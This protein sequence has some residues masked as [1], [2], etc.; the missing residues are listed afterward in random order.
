MATF[1]GGVSVASWRAVPKAGGAI[2]MGRGAIPKGAI[3]K[4]GEVPRRRASWGVQHPSSLPSDRQASSGEGGGCRGGQLRAVAAAVKTAS[5]SGWESG[6][7]SGL[8]SESGRGSG[9]ADPPKPEQAH[10]LRPH[11]ARP[12]WRRRHPHSPRWQP[13][14]WWRPPSPRW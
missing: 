4:G 12:R 14:R 13:P 6:W 9:L 5:E 10:P 8:D 1:E 11:A 3:R 2:P 7:E